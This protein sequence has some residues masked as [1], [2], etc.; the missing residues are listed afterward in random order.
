MR[1]AGHQQKLVA[2]FV[3]KDQGIRKK[4]DG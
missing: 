3:I 1:S 4:R 2:F